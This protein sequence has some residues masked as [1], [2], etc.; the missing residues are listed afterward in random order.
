MRCTRGQAA[1]D[2]V[3][4]IAVVAIL[5][6]A[7]VAIAA[8]GAAGVVNAVVAQVRHALCLVGGGPC[9]HRGTQPCTVASTRDT[10]HWMV[11]VLLLRVDRE[12]YVLREEM[13]DGTVRLTVARRG[14]AGPEA[15]VGGHLRVTRGG[16]NAG[17]T[18]EVRGAVQLATARGSVYVAR[19]AREAAAI[20]RAIRAGDE[21]P[22]QVRETLR[23]GGIRG[24][25]SLGVGSALAGASLEAMAPAMIGSRSDHS[26]GDLTLTLN[27]G[28]SGWATVTAALGGPAG[29]AGRATTIGLKLDRARRP[30]ELSVLAAGTV[31]AGAALPPLLARASRGSATTAAKGAGGRRWELTARLDL[32]DPVVAAAWRRYRRDPGGEAAIGGL[33]AALRERASLDVRMYRTS[34]VTSGASAG[35]GEILQLSGGVDRTVDRSRLLAAASRPSDGVWERRWDC[36]MT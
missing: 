17:A 1:V 18:G 11:G 5:L 23:E 16:R 4:L 15:V 31:A 3:A 24:V 36:V 14:A 20:M 30:T 10:R 12:R 9:S 26:T 13:S 7:G 6:A 34:S 27:A 22:A 2:Y 35:I 28:A 25:A 19:D 21:P 29:N 33:A 32:R 8:G